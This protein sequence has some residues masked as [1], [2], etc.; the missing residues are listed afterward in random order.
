MLLP[1]LAHVFLCQDGAGVGMGVSRDVMA[2]A[3]RLWAARKRSAEGGGHVPANG[4]Q[5]GSDKQ[6]TCR[7][8]STPSPR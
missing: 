3:P 7:S 1:V 8:S 2:A 5:L 6:V 4:L